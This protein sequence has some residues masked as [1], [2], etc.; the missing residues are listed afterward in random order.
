MGRLGV[1]LRLNALA[2]EDDVAR[3]RPDVVILAT[4]GLPDVGH[5][6]GRDLANTVWDVLSGQCEIGRDALVFDESGGHTALSCAQFMA[7]KGARVEIVTPDKSLGLELSDTNLGAHMSELYKAGSVVTPDA[8]LV[9]VVRDGNKLRA[10]LEN[11]YSGTRGER[12]VDQVIGDYGTVPNLDLYKALKPIS[13]NLG[14]MD[15][16]TL[17]AAAA[18]T[19]ETNP[20]GSF[21]LYRIGDAWA[22]RNIHAAM[23]DAMRICKDL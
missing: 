21:F 1:D 16:K 15:L 3:E 5:F 9:E 19:I 10:V 6:A 23:L 4:G 14:D 11:T 20:D 12:V 22:C 17:A 8:R 2:D 13:R 7:A 18:Q